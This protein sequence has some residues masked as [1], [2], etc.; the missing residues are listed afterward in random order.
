M[1]ILPDGSRH[2]PRIGSTEFRKIAPIKRFQAVQIAATT[3]ELRLIVDA[4]LTQEQQEA[5][6]KLIHQHIGYPFAILFR[7]LNAFPAGKFEEFQVMIG[8][9]S[10]S[11]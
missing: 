5:I 8:Q 1:V 4:P 9:R 6:C 10:A 2:W 7:Y 11:S 3:L